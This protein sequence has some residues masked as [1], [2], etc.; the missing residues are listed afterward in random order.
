MMPAKALFPEVIVML[1]LAYIKHFL[2]Y[3]TNFY[4]AVKKISI[5]GVI[6]KNKYAYNVYRFSISV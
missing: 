4:I 6:A 2:C 3:F 5:G 1:S